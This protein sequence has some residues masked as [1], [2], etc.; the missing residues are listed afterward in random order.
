[1]ENKTIEFVG[2]VIELAPEGEFK[3]VDEQ[4][5]A[6]RDVHFTNRVICTHGRKKVTLDGVMVKAI[7]NAYEGDVD[8]REWCEK[9]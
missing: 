4:T 5:G 7:H 3:A 8:L 9:C 6:V 2:G 1:M